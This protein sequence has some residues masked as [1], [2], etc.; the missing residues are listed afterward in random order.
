MPIIITNLT[1]APLPLPDLLISDIPALG[2]NISD[3]TIAYV[4]L[5]KVSADLDAA[6]RDNTAKA[7]SSFDG[8]GD[9]YKPT[10]LR[11]QLDGRIK[12][13][14]NKLT[15]MIDLAMMDADLGP[16][17]ERRVSQG[18]HSLFMPPGV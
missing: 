16:G 5:V 11:L 1:N 2:Q 12:K 9:T 15:S 18:V 14:P 3:A 6:I 8:V 4:A 13:I 10:L 7:T 17:V